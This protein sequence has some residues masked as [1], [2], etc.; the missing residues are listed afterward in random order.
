[1][2]DE[3]D[4][5]KYLP[6]LFGVP[7]SIKDNIEMQGTRSTMGLTKRALKKH[8]AD[9]IFPICAKN[10]GMIPF[11]KSNVPQMCMTYDSTNFL[12]GH[13]LNP[14]NLKKSAGGS[15]GGEGALVAAK[16]SPI[17]I[18]NDLLGSVRIPAAFNG[19][20]GLMSSAGRLPLFNTAT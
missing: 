18:G 20:V 6:P 14:W 5:E 12:W 8:E 11:V 2:N 10:S 1:L 9:S 3:Y 13:C 17:G 4:S 7:I 19:V 16:L 15:S